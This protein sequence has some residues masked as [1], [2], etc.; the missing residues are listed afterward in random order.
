MFEGQYKVI[1][2]KYYKH[3]KE[4]AQHKQSFGQIKMGWFLADQLVH[5]VKTWNPK[6]YSILYF[7]PELLIQ[8]RVYFHPKMLKRER[9]NPWFKLFNMTEDK[10]SV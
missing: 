10:V 7:K 6:Q 2:P 1:H 3:F 8:F 9:N 5:Q 4:D